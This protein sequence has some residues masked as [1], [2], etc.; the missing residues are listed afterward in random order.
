MRNTRYVQVT[1]RVCG[2]MVRIMGD[3]SVP[4]IFPDYR[5]PLREGIRGE[6]SAAAAVDAGSGD[7]SGP[8]SAMV[9][10]FAIRT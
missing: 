9:R 5:V 6:G 7:S 1:C 8:S 4:E 10:L 3:Q 2:A